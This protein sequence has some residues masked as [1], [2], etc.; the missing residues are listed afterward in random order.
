MGFYEASLLVLLLAV[1]EATAASCPAGTYLKD[2]KCF[3]CPVGYFESEGTCK[4]CPLDQYN[5]AE[6]GTG[7]TA[8]PEGTKTLEKGSVSIDQC[9]KVCEIPATYKSGYRVTDDTQIYTVSA[10]ERVAHDTNLLFVCDPGYQFGNTN[11]NTQSRTCSESVDLPTFCIRIE[12]S[13]KGEG[14]FT[15]EIE[16][17]TVSCSVYPKEQTE[18]TSVYFFKDDVKITDGVVLV[19]KED[20][21]EATYEVNEEGRWRCAL[22]DTITDESNKPVTEAL[23]SKLTLTMNKPTKLAVS[24]DEDYTISCESSYLDTM[25]LPGLVLYFNGEP[26]S[27][28]TSE[29]LDQKFRVSK[30]FS[31]LTNE[32]AGRYTCKSTWA[33]TDGDVI[34]PS[35]V[36]GTVDFLG[37]QT[38]YPA[39]EDGTSADVVMVSAD[40]DVTLVCDTYTISSGSQPDVKFFVNDVEVGTGTSHTLTVSTSGTEVHCTASVGTGE[41]Q[42]L[43]TTKKTT[44]LTTDLRVEM[45]PE[46]LYGKEGDI[47]TLTCSLTGANVQ[48]AV[49]NTYLDGSSKLT[50]DSSAATADGTYKFEITINKTNTWA[51]CGVYVADQKV[52]FYSVPI[53]VY[54]RD[55]SVEPASLVLLQG[56]GSSFT[57]KVWGDSASVTVSNSEIRAVKNEAESNAWMTHYDVPITNAKTKWYGPLDFSITYSDDK[58]LAVENTNLYVTDV[59]VKT[60]SNNIAEEQNIVLT[61]SHVNP[62]NYNPPTVTWYIYKGQDD[63]LFD[64]DKE[65]FD[66]S[67]SS[68]VD[69]TDSTDSKDETVLTI[70]NVAD[71]DTGFYACRVEFRNQSDEV[72]LERMAAPVKQTVVGEAYFHEMPKS[73]GVRVDSSLEISCTA[74]QQRP[75]N[76]PSEPKIGVECYN[77]ESENWTEK[78]SRTTTKT[79]KEF[80]EKFQV[81]VTASMNNRDC[82]CFGNFY[83]GGGQEYLISSPLVRVYAY[84]VRRYPGYNE[85]HYSMKGHSVTMKCSANGDGSE[86]IQWEKGTARISNSDTKYTITTGEV[87]DGTYSST[88][89]I[90]QITPALDGEFTCY[91]TYGGDNGVKL[92]E[93]FTLHV[94]YITEFSTATRY[95]NNDTTATIT[96]KVSQVDDKIPTITWNQDGKI[97][98]G[99]LDDSII[100][101]STK[102]CVLQLYITEEL[103]RTVNCSLEYREQPSLKGQKETSSRVT[104]VSQRVWSDQPKVTVVDGGNAEYVCYASGNTDVMMATLNYPGDPQPKVEKDAAKYQS[105]FTFDMADIRAGRSGDYTCQLNFA[106]PMSIE[107]SV[108]IMVL[109]EKFPA[110]ETYQTLGQ[111]QNFTCAT[112]L[113]GEN[114]IAKIRFDGGPGAYK[115]QFKYFDE[116]GEASNTL[117]LNLTQA[118]NLKVYNCSVEIEGSDSDRPLTSE[119][120]L[121]VQYVK[122][123]KNKYYGTDKQTLDIPCVGSGRNSDVDGISWTLPA[124]SS[125]SGTKQNYVQATFSLKTVLTVALTPEKE[126]E[127]TC[128]VAYDPHPHQD[129]LSL[130]IL[131]IEANPKKTYYL[132]KGSVGTIVCEGTAPLSS[133]KPSFKWNYVDKINTG[134]QEQCG[135][136]FNPNFAGTLPGPTNRR[137]GTVEISTIEHTIVESD[138]LRSVDCTMSWTGTDAD[139]SLTTTP[140]LLVVTYIAADDEVYVIEGKDGTITCTVYG[141]SVQMRWEKENEDKT[142]WTEITQGVAGYDTADGN[143]DETCHRESFILTVKSTDESSEGKYRCSSTINYDGN[144]I[145]LKKTVQLKV[146][147]VVKF[148]VGLESGR[149]TSA[150]ITQFDSASLACSASYTGGTFSFIKKVE[151]QEEVPQSSDYEVDTDDGYRAAGWN[152]QSFD[153]DHVGVYECKV[154]WGGLPA[155]VKTVNLDISRVCQRPDIVNGKLITEDP[156]S[157]W[158]KSGETGTVTCEEGYTLSGEATVKCDEGDLVTPTGAA[159]QATCEKV[160]SERCVVLPVPA[161][162]KFSCKTVEGN[163]VCNVECNEGY[164]ISD[165]ANNEYTCRSESDENWDH[166]TQQNPLGKTATCDEKTYQK[167]TLQGPCTE[168]SGECAEKLKDYTCVAGTITLRSLL[169]AEEVKKELQPSGGKR[170]RD[171]TTEFTLTES[172]CIGEGSVKPMGSQYCVKCSAGYYASDNTCKP[173]AVGQYGSSPGLSLCIYCDAGLSTL[174]QAASSSSECIEVCEIP[175]VHRGSSYPPTGFLVKAGSTVTLSCEEGFDLEYNQ[176]SEVTCS[177]QLPKC[178]GRCRV[179]GPDSYDNLGL[180]KVEI[181]AESISQ[182]TGPSTLCN[183]DNGD[184]K[185][186]E[187]GNDPKIPHGFPIKA[188]CMDVKEMKN[189]KS[190]QILYCQEET[191]EF[192]FPDCSECKVDCSTSEWQCNSDCSCIPKTKRCDKIKDCKINT[193]KPEI[194]DEYDCSL[195]NDNPRGIQFDHWQDETSPNTPVRFSYTPRSDW[196]Q[197]AACFWL[198]SSFKGPQTVFSYGGKIGVSVHNEELAVHFNLDGTSG[199]TFSSRAAGITD[200]NYHRVCVSWNSVGGVVDLYYEDNDII[201]D[202]KFKTWS[203]SSTNLTN[204]RISQTVILTVGGTADQK[205]PNSFHG[206]IKDMIIFEKQLITEDIDNFRDCTFPAANSTRIKWEAILGV[207]GSKKVMNYEKTNCKAPTCKGSCPVDMFMC[208]TCDCVSPWQRCDLFTQHCID[209]SDEQ[210]CKKTNGVFKPYNE[211]KRFEE[212]KGSCIQ[213]GGN[214]AFIDS[215][216]E[217]NLSARSLAIDKIRTTWIGMTVVKGKALT[218]W[219]SG[220]YKSEWAQSYYSDTTKVDTSVG[221]R[222]DRIWL[223]V[224]GLFAEKLPYLCRTQGYLIA[225]LDETDISI[226]DWRSSCTTHFTIADEYYSDIA[227]SVLKSRALHVIDNW[228]GVAWVKSDLNCDYIKSDRSVTVDSP[229]ECTTYWNVPSFC[230]VQVELEQVTQASLTGEENSFF[231][232]DNPWSGK[233]DSDRGTSELSVCF[234]LK[235]ADEAGTVLRYSTADYPNE[236]LI[237][238]STKSQHQ[239]VDIL[240]LTVHNRVNFFA[241]ELLDGVWHSVCVAWGTA[242]AA[243]VTGSV[244][245]MVDGAEISQ[246]KTLAVWP[247]NLYNAKLGDQGKLYIGR[248]GDSSSTDSRSLKGAIMNL[249]VW[250]KELSLEEMTQMTRNSVDSFKCGP[251]VVQESKLILRWRDLLH[252][253]SSGVTVSTTRDHVHCG[254]LYYGAEFAAGPDGTKIQLESGGNSGKDYSQAVRYGD[255]VRIVKGGTSD[256]TVKC[257]GVSCPFTQCSDSNTE[258][259][260]EF[261]VLSDIWELGR[262]VAVS[263]KIVLRTGDKVIRGLTASSGDLSLDADNEEEDNSFTVTVDYVGWKDGTISECGDDCVKTVTR[264]CV[265]FDGSETDGDGEDTLC[266]G[267]REISRYC[268]CSDHGECAAPPAASEYSGTYTWVVYDKSEPGY[269]FAICP[270]GSFADRYVPKTVIAEC[271]GDG[272]VFENTTCSFQSEA[273]Q[274]L[275]KILFDIQVE[276]DNVAEVAAQTSQAIVKADDLGTVHVNLAAD[277]TTKVAN[278]TN[279]T[280]DVVDNVLNVF[281]TLTIT[282]SDED[283]QSSKDDSGAPKKLVDSI[284]TAAKKMKPET[285]KPITLKKKSVGLKVMDVPET[286]TGSV[287]FSISKTAS[288][289]IDEV[290]FGDTVPSSDPV[291]EKRTRQ[292][293]ISGSQDN[294]TGS[295]DNGTGSQDNGLDDTVLGTEE[296]PAAEANMTVSIEIAADVAI[297]TKQLSFMVYNNSKMFV[298][299]K[300]HTISTNA[301]I[302]NPFESGSLSIQSNVLGGSVDQETAGETGVGSG[303]STPAATLTMSAQGGI[304]LDRTPYCVYWDDV[305][306]MWSQTGLHITSC[307]PDKISCTS[308]HL[309]NFAVLMNIGDNAFSPAHTTAMSVLTIVGSS[310]SILSLTLTVVGLA[311]GKMR[312]NPTYHIHLFLALSLGLAMLFM[313]VGMDRR[314]NFYVCKVFAVL[315]HYMFLASICWMLVE[316]VNLYIALII[317]F[318]VNHKKLKIAAHCFSWGFPALVCLITVLVDT[319]VAGFELYEICMTAKYCFLNHRGR[320]YFFVAPIMLA[321]AVNVFI[322]IRVIIVLA[323]ATK[324]RDGW[325]DLRQ[326]TVIASITGMSISLVTVI[327]SITGIS[328]I[329]GAMTVGGSVGTLIFNYLYIILN[330]FQGVVIFYFHCFGKP[331]VR[332]AWTEKLSSGTSRLFTSSNNSQAPASYGKSIVPVEVAKAR[333]ISEVAANKAARGESNLSPAEL[334]ALEKCG[335]TSRKISTAATGVSDQRYSTTVAP[336]IS[337]TL[338]P[339]GRISTV[340]NPGPRLGAGANRPNRFSVAGYNTPLSPMP[341]QASPNPRKIEEE[342][343]KLQNMEKTDEEAAYS[344]IDDVAPENPEKTGTGLRRRKKKQENDCL[345]EENQYVTLGEKEDREKKNADK[346]GDLAIE[347]VEL[348]P[349]EPEPAVSGS[350]LKRCES[351]EGAAITGPDI[352]YFPDDDTGSI[353]M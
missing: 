165:P 292:G 113:I 204:L 75:D 46:V 123:E 305:E 155:P 19:V 150:I 163:L 328:W 133:M 296:P 218:T 90:S 329:F 66:T 31:S 205:D 264:N 135:T 81:T 115:D 67:D 313:L 319:Y 79:T 108:E 9:I 60:Y 26:V 233:L 206:F 140:S 55:S 162:G 325:T 110:T 263:D 147:R 73:L 272:A 350:T 346:K 304:D 344:T 337:T 70:S 321:M 42:Q 317:V 295:Q 312:R 245:L 45:S 94:L 320:M 62:P 168:C 255:I 203:V 53:R 231:L 143:W 15:P 219:E 327:A 138:Q 339:G 139:G 345:V 199:A 353:N 297:K 285:G 88:L 249:N 97:S 20:Y 224:Y 14:Y 173:C 4:Q 307:D 30:S 35:Q 238:L 125:T 38:E 145:E 196:Q 44:L 22:A 201:D 47:V 1:K 33:I 262:A 309:T 61:C 131:K 229:A 134:K 251:I 120:Q 2:N 89:E 87:I 318:G 12:A 268:P 52:Y 284:E 91:V 72:R 271:A 86:V 39:R 301:A 184:I 159:L 293:E 176:K 207:A 7:C 74:D 244:N 158:I 217:N 315:I 212:S 266:P 175:A 10:G 130:T 288:Q 121:V 105:K 156:E 23:I 126:G 104:V 34:G 128:G 351:L 335:G 223:P 316:G 149:S 179:K 280:E 21:Q 167:F 59:I 243:Q 17:I 153:E 182:D 56:Q 28:V 116:E 287:S 306:E 157:R 169:S 71:T 330:S 352:V 343:I 198:Q 77:S 129:S 164:L 220:S 279:I 161:N 13:Q 240:E 241:V 232:L 107:V 230:G 146:Y 195:P 308:D 98:T 202:D 215:E 286:Q 294:G 326:V 183:N 227:I 333:P 282:V 114:T 78:G 253:S 51:R 36:E 80:T 50:T 142:G 269:W 237:Y 171:T 63:G 267:D 336:R 323:K 189:G 127:Y 209:N 83:D 278:V 170:K 96:C 277:I 106:P 300:N 93:T 322:F 216:F 221:L 225:K 132:E 100:S 258:C 276:D 11:T 151:G 242:T 194:S 273:A 54:C 181:G 256:R 265:K 186:S 95:E 197:F 68:R 124:G 40:T 275:Y 208:G 6:Q 118:M 84:D 37:F 213:A 254:I 299:S 76:A 331:D 338:G 69:V 122:L 310:L 32:V 112:E 311:I 154:E 246:Y 214:L 210:D 226:D 347:D 148:E 18:A 137:S 261:T 283:I 298:A 349:V 99:C 200:G 248:Q 270:Y 341:F 250:K 65:E 193:A 274:E 188:V 177:D 303:R 48:L 260:T 174:G 332:N 302:G 152:I 191:L 236:I 101:G 334:A 85:K 160:P 16:T 43:V 8:C 239:P 192:I 252:Y 291:T 49:L 342:D 102:T 136:Q 314:E 109:T 234:N 64:S 340:S 180:K 27:S 111:I 247:K 228:Q 324:N 119:G 82:R 178:Y 259:G 187:S 172:Q 190:E 41:S 235:S 24:T 281:D 289:A 57:L 348:A 58:E 144:V 29:I 257:D 5:A 3:V 92:E 211:Q 290:E 141:P 185:C 25:G 103:L 117:S 222:D 166:V